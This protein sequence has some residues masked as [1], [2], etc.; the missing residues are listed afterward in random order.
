LIGS[1]R[2]IERRLLQLVASTIEIARG[3][4]SQRARAMCDYFLQRMEGGQ[5]GG[6]GD[7]TDVV[8]AGGA[9]PR[10]AEVPCTAAAEWQLQGEPLSLLFPPPPPSSSSDGGCL[11]T[12]GADVFCDPFSGLGLGDPFS[13]DYSSG[14]GFLDAM[15][16]AM[17]RVGFDDTAVRGG[18]G[19]GGEQLLDMSRKP[20][21]PRGMQMP[22]VGLLGPTRVLPSPLSPRAIR[23]YPPMGGDMVKFG[24]TAGQMA[25]C[26]IDA[27]V[28]GM[29][30]S[31]PRAAGGIKRR[32]C[33]SNN[34]LVASCLHV[35]I[36]HT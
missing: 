5:A 19:R 24:I 28:V 17:D 18:G 34:C 22:A 15:P 36:L 4:P 30:M 8:R 31:S 35:H 32:L 1:K 26:A 11:G 29:Q 9:I 33:R 13:S 12:T 21:L 27:A 25:G 20:L 23:P 6:D 2:I 16:D 10:N 14:A 3:R 7:L